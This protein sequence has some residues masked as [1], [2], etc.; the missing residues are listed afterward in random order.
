M[1]KLSETCKSSSPFSNRLWQSEGSPAMS[2]RRGRNLRNLR[3]LSPP[4]FHPCWRRRLAPETWESAWCQN[5][6]LCCV[7]SP[8]Q[9]IISHLGRVSRIG[10][11]YLL[12]ASVTSLGSPNFLKPSIKPSTVTR[13]EASPKNLRTDMKRSFVS[14]KLNWS[15]LSLKKK[16]SFFQHQSNF[17]VSSNLPVDCSKEFH[18]V[19][20]TFLL[21]IRIIR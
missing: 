15:S 18:H 13:H 7:S 16:T 17:H 1:K 14:T 12:T 19:F 11:R 9:F 5:L 3:V 10:T 20:G 2:R 21:E 6:L 4:S 8:W